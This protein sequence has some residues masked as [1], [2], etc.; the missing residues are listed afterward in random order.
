MLIEQY[1]GVRQTR[2]DVVSVRQAEAL[3]LLL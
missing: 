2:H 3:C 1:V